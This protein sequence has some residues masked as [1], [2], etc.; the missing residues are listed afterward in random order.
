M[1]LIENPKVFCQKMAE[2]ETYQLLAAARLQNDTKAIQEH[3]LAIC[4]EVQSYLR[5]LGKEIGQKFCQQDNG[6]ILA[7]LEFQH[8]HS[9]LRQTATELLPIWWEIKV[10]LDARGLSQRQINQRLQWN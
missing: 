9:S 1:D 5:K 4:R 10:F 7:A 8:L 2:S 3:F 6:A